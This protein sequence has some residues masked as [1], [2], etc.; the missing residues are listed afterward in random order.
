MNSLIQDINDAIPILNLVLV[1]SGVNLNG[2]SNTRGGN[3]I[4][5][6]RLLQAANYITQEGDTIGPDFDLVVYSIFYNPSR[7]KY[8]DGKV[9]DLVAI[10]WKETYARSKVTINR[11]SEFDYQ[12]KVIESFNDGR[13]HEDDDEPGK[14]VVNLKSIQSMFFTASGKLLRLES[15]NTP[16]LILKI[17]NADNEEEWIALGELHEGEFEDEDD[18]DDDDDEEEEKNTKQLKPKDI[19]SSSLSLLEY[20]IRLCRLQQIE[21]KSIL[22]IP[23]EILTLYLH[24]QQHNGE[25]PKS[26]SQKRKEEFNK[27]VKESAIAMDSN[28]RRL[29]NLDLKEK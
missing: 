25:L 11:K 20:L 8:I 2:S 28:I 3:G 14:I 19:K 7:L 21:H 26:V 10:S 9:D 16:V 23:D 15:R 29:N 22:E 27:V 12:L 5:P 1:T 4:S 24:D 17:I 6:G 18:D 13:Y